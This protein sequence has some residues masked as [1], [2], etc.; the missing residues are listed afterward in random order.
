VFWD[1]ACGFLPS[2][3]FLNASPQKS[4]DTPGTWLAP[5]STLFADLVLALGDKNGFIEYKALRE[6]AGDFPPPIPPT[7][8]T[9]QTEP[10][11]RYKSPA[12]ERRHFST[13]WPWR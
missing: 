3:V 2:F 10:Q 6:G 1:G 7:P 4:D 12:C 9:T 13:V 11:P 8:A 5:S